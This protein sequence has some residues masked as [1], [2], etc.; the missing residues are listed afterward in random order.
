[1]DP[2][3]DWSTDAECRLHGGRLRC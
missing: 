1:V 3:N 2:F